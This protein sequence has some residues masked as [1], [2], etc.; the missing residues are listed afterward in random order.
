MSIPAIVVVFVLG[1][2]V[3]RWLAEPRNRATTPQNKR[4]TRLLPLLGV[5][6]V[7]LLVGLGVAPVAH[8]YSTVRV[9]A[10]NGTTHQAPLAEM[11]FSDIPAQFG[12]HDPG[13]GAIV[14]SE[15]ELTKIG[16][17]LLVALAAL[18]IIFIPLGALAKLIVKLTLV[19]CV[20]IIVLVFIRS[21]RM[22]AAVD[23][24]NRGV[25]I[26]TATPYE[27][28]VEMEKVPLKIDSNENGLT[29]SSQAITASETVKKS[30][31]EDKPASA[32]DTPDWVTSPPQDTKADVRLIESGRY[33]TLDE[34]DAG[35]IDK[36]EAQARA[37]LATLDLPINV[38]DVQIDRE[39]LRKVGLLGKKTKQFVKHVET[40][41]GE[42]QSKFALVQFGDLKDYLGRLAHDT[43]VE[44][45]LSR[46]GEFAAA[47]LAGLAGVYGL[48]RFKSRSTVAAR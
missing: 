14:S 44:E 24:I 48:L 7:A 21:S 10:Q 5:I 23:T 27:A 20:A 32:S 34:C 9:T 3:V 13:V 8:T 19:S 17:L 41:Y 1:M 42:M 35:L 28:V 30:P 43:A 46:V 16:V 38:H 33:V 45:R 2:I 6:G 11:D 31:V 12:I 4:F 47:I 36:L 40:Q 37:Y 18:A 26:P 22:G 15:P 29:A 25:A 39:V